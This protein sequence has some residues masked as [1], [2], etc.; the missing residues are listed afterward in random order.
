[1]ESKKDSG[2][3]SNRS[4][5]QAAERTLPPSLGAAGVG[6][7]QAELIRR[8][9][10]PELADGGYCGMVPSAECHT[11]TIR[12]P[13]PPKGLHKSF[14][15]AEGARPANPCQA[16]MIIHTS[17]SAPSPNTELPTKSPG[18]YLFLLLISPECLSRG[19]VSGPSEG[20]WGIQA[21]FPSSSELSPT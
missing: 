10:W 19:H 16:G 18:T 21:T 2:G 12:S 13:V 4:S 11:V 1:M 8:H 17:I 7:Q 6:Q 15:S 3:E 14:L 9:P 5:P 20:I